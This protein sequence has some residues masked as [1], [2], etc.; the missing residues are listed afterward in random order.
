MM[1]PGGGLQ[2]AVCADGVAMW[3]KSV[4]WIGWPTCG[5]VSQW[6]TGRTSSGL[7][8]T[9]AQPSRS[10]RTVR[11]WVPSGASQ[12]SPHSPLR[13]PRTTSTSVPRC[14]G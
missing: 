14:K 3:V 1:M 12:I 9:R 13:L 2:C 7:M 8:F 10:R 11:L 6:L 4:V 5:D